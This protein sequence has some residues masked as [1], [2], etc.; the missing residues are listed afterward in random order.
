M[1]IDTAVYRE[2]RTQYDARQYAAAK[3]LAEKLVQLTEEQYGPEELRVDQSAD[4]SRHGATTSW[5]TTRRRSRT[6]SARCASCRPS[7]RWPT[8]SRSARCTASGV[9]FMGANDP[10]SAVVALKRAADL[11][12][13]TDG[14]FNIGQ[15]EFIDALID[16]YAATGRWPRRK[17]KALYAMRV[18][19]AAYGRSSVKLLDRLDKLARWYEAERRYTSERNVYER[20]LDH[21]AEERARKRP[22]ARGAAARHRALVPAR[23]RSTASKVPTRG[24]TFNSGAAGAPVFAD[25]TQQRR[26]ESAL[27]TALAVIDANIA[28]RPAAARRSAR[29]PGRLV[30][31]R[32]THCAAPMT[33][34]PTPGRPSRR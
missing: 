20:A 2:F 1:P 16:A 6:T 17:R 28:G 10:E 3:P 18:E 7:R 32:R 8:S 14:L 22:A 25:G 24:G 29:R 11:S 33:P 30:P 5:A 12:R 13:N 4:Q 27:T 9:S 23:D 21:P 15:I 26:G 19:E 31:G 34:M